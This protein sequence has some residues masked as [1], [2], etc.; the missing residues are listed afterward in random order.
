MLFTGLSSWSLCRHLFPICVIFVFRKQYSQI[1]ILF[2]S[3]SFTIVIIPAQV[4]WPFYPVQY[5]NIFTHVV[6]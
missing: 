2:H 6:T 4:P 5:R 1:Y 3:P